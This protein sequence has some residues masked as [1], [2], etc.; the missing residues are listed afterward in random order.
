MN[1]DITPLQND[2]VIYESLMDMDQEHLVSEMINTV[3][4]N[5]NISLLDYLKTFNYSED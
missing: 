4:N 3:E 1:N 2:D 5:P